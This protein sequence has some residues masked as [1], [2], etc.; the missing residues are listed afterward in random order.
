VD[1]HCSGDADGRG[2]CA[3]VVNAVHSSARSGGVEHAL[4]LLLLLHQSDPR[5]DLSSDLRASVIDT[6]G[7][8]DGTIIDGWLHAAASAS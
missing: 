1:D 6:V 4:L 3:G 5:T 7:D 2:D 8:R